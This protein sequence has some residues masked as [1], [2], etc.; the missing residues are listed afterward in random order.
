M[1]SMH[2]RA[3]VAAY[4]LFV[5]WAGNP[6]N[7]L[8]GSVYPEPANARV[9]LLSNTVK[10]VEKCRTDVDSQSGRVGQGH[11]SILHQHPANRAINRK[12]CVH[13][14]VGKNDIFLRAHQMSAVSQGHASLKHAANHTGD[15]GAGSHRG[16]LRAPQY[17][18]PTSSVL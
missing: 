16:D 7:K 2:F 18:P 10:L 4:K 14:Q 1:K 8:A 13:I 12:H 9:S 6:G 11:D 17:A 15:S 3:A 5:E